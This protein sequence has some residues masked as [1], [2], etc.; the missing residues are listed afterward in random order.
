MKGRH[1]IS[2]LQRKR[3]K[4]FLQEARRFDEKECESLWQCEGRPSVTFSASPSH[5]LCSPVHPFGCPWLTHALQ[6]LSRT[7]SARQHMGGHS[8]LA[9]LCFPGP[10]GPWQLPAEPGAA[11][12]LRQWDLESHVRRLRVRQG[13]RPS[14]PGRGKA[15]CGPHFCRLL[16]PTGMFQNPSSAERRRE[17]EVSKRQPPRH[18]AHTA[19]AGPAL[20]DADAGARINAQ[21]RNHVNEGNQHF[22]LIAPFPS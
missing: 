1:L 19:T 5:V 13:P 14:G 21:T 2:N 16:A 22:G 15:G 6:N 11:K 18:A 12:S 9:D 8:M 10:R 3:Q 20:C 4:S 17:R 7:P